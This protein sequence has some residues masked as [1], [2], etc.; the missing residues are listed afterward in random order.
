MYLGGIMLFKGVAQKVWFNTFGGVLADFFVVAFLILV[1]A[2]AKMYYRIKSFDESFSR[3]LTKKLLI[4]FICLIVMVLAVTIIV[5]TT[6]DK[7]I[8]WTVVSNVIYFICALGLLLSAWRLN[9]LMPPR[10][11]IFLHKKIKTIF[12]TIFV[13]TLLHLIRIPALTLYVIYHSKLSNLQIGI[14]LVFYYLV[15]ELIPPCLILFFVFVPESTKK[16]VSIPTNNVDQNEPI[17]SNQD[18]ETEEEMFFGDLS[19]S[20]N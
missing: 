13:C 6:T 11:F 17:Y 15:A 12:R 1:F 7:R 2:L 8:V 18:E 10:Q 16:I 4:F 20:S 3:K 9:Q 5:R 19:N 14:Y